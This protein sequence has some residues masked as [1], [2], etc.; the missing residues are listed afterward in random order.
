M[1]K[2]ALS[3]ITTVAIA[4]ANPAATTGVKAPVTTEAVKADVNAPVTKEAAKADVNAT[5]PAVVAAK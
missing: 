5:T 1:Q 4:L 3:L 2:I